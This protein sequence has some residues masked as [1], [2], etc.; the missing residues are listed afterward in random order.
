LAAS[1]WAWLLGLRP[2][3]VVWAWPSGC[4]R[5]FAAGFGGKKLFAKNGHPPK[6]FFKKNPLRHPS[7]NFFKKVF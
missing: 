6:N 2:G 4:W 5:F 7:T 1:F 3:L